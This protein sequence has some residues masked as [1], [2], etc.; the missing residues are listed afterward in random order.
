MVKGEELI[1]CE[2]VDWLGT[3]W[4]LNFWHRTKKKFANSSLKNETYGKEVLFQAAASI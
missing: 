2:K 4:S 1:G 3:V